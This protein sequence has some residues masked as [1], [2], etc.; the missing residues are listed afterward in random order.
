[1]T[2]QMLPV[3]QPDPSHGPAPADAGKYAPLDGARLFVPMAGAV[4]SVGT[5]TVGDFLRRIVATMP[6]DTASVA[7]LPGV[8]VPAGWATVDVTAVWCPAVDTGG[9]VRVRVDTKLDSPGTRVTNYPISGT[10]TDIAA[11]LVVGEVVHSEL[12]TAAAVTPGHLLTLVIAR[13]GDVAVDTLAGNMH[14][15]GLI[16]ERAS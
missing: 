13:R 8:V 16:V 2:T 15:L 1:M 10:P 11:P 4:Q 12:L 3:P 9:S 6:A 7:A 5:V 14:W